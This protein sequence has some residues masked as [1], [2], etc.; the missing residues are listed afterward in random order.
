MYSSSALPLQ[1]SRKGQTETKSVKIL[2]R[3]KKV[4][5]QAKKRLKTKTNCL[6]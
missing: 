5:M 4:S 2:D 3:A 1:L 6:Y